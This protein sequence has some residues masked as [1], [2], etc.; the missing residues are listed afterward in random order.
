MLKYQTVC[1][2]ITTIL[3]PFLTLELSDNTTIPIVNNSD[4]I[5]VIVIVS[6]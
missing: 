1:H 6:R 4:Q 2:N 3:F 5:V